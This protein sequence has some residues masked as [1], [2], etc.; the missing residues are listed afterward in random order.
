MGHILWVFLGG[1]FLVVVS[2]IGYIYYVKGALEYK[3]AKE[4][5]V[6]WVRSYKW[7]CTGANRYIV[8]VETLQNSFLEYET[9]IIERVW[10]DLIHERLIELD[11][12][13]GVW[14]IK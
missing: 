2:L 9:T 14:C 5:I 13:D 1:V 7:K 8:T 3:K 4:E 10:L 6:P 11:P 12:H